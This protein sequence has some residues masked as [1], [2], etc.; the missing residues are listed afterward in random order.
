MPKHPK[1]V[2][3]EGFKGINNISRPE[4]TPIDYLKEAINVD[5]AKDGSVH[6]R[7]G[8][9]EVFSGS[10][11]HSLWSNNDHCYFVDNNI[12][13]Y[14]YINYTSKNI[15]T[16]CYDRISYVELN[17]EVY[18]TSRSTTGILN[19][20]TYREFGIQEPNWKP[21]LTSGNGLL[22]GGRYQI[23]VSYVDGDGRESGTKLAT[24]I[25]V[26]DSSSI[27][28]SDMKASDNSDVEYIRI[29][30]TTPDGIVLYRLVDLPDTTTTYTINDIRHAVTPIDN[31]GIKAAPFGDLITYYNSRMYIADGNVLYASQPLSYEW[32][33]IRKDF[34]QFSSDITMLMPVDKGIYV[35]LQN[36][37]VYLSGG[38]ISSFSLDEKEI[39][40]PVMYSN[41]QIPSGY[42][43][44]DNTPLGP[45]WL[46]TADE[47][48]FVCM[49]QG[50][51]FNVTAANVAFPTGAEGTAGFIQQDGINKYVSLIK[52]QNTED[53]NASFSDMVTA[54]VI[55][56]GIQIT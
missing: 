34:I 54:D 13:K 50:V 22:T 16:D 21:T 17:G 8:Y 53:Q 7:K 45:K 3:L 42:I 51:M 32:F 38:D 27:T 25:S 43:R 19:G 2:S 41:V 20:S 24:V 35:G 29:Y 40:H 5:I 46:F 10:N 36:K 11:S 28:L 23:S 55:R 44:I 37:L 26:S 15:K 30:I 6:K 47:G 12:L 56:N 14:L 48:I 4:N 49:N 39:C 18:F 52:D 1:T 9:D 31:L 33:D